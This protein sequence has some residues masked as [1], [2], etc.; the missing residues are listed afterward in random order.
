MD[1]LLCNKSKL[2]GKEFFNKTD[3]FNLYNFICGDLSFDKE[4]VF[5]L[6][7]M[8]VNSVDSKESI[9]G[10]NKLL[11][12]Q[13]VNEKLFVTGASCL[14]ELIYKEIMKKY[15]FINSSN[16][17]DIF[18]KEKNDVWDLLRHIENALK[19]VNSNEERGT[20]FFGYFG[21]ET[22]HYVE[23]MSHYKEDT[24]D[25]PVISLS[26][27]EHIITLADADASLTTY[28]FNK[29]NSHN[30]FLKLLSKFIKKEYLEFPVF[31]DD[32]KFKL[33]FET[34]KSSYLEKSCK[35]LTHIEIGDIYQVQIGQKLNIESEIDA[36][37]VYKN[38]R[39]QNPSPYMYLFH[40]NNY[41]VVGASPE[42]F[43]KVNEKEILMRPIA[44]TIGKTNISNKQEAL[45]HL[46]ADEKEVAEH[47]MLVDLCRNDLHRVCDSESVAVADLMAIEEYS[48][49]YHMVSSTSGELSNQYDKFDA[50]QATFPAGTMTGTPK[51]RAM[52]LIDEIEDSRRGL[53][54]GAI[55]LIGFGANY[56][57]TALCIR[58]AIKKENVYTL[59]A[60]AG[61]VSD[62]LPESEY[63]ETLYKLGAMF[64]AVTGEEISCHLK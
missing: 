30:I 51:I 16:S 18:L 23:N 25:L 32:L 8:G 2:K 48:H 7:S 44:G 20:V 9:I 28:Y 14:R 12:I 61:M 3:A 43:I 37:S 10:V 52:E 62:S 39:Q 33:F 41:T 13:V 11:N 29:E 40:V 31:K 63:N 15:E 57:N 64:K 60:S 50:I 5:L 21:Y 22:I 42:L 26:L 1:R 24:T 47:L 27:Y 45:D 53:Y 6:E 19:I 59:R 4:E 54:A 55:G 34:T 38:L 17:L 36:L 46:H 58:T 56:M 35:A 49:V